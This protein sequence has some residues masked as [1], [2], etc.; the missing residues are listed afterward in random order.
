MQE[1]SS[2]LRPKEGRTLSA[3]VEDSSVG[4][5]GNDGVGDPSPEDD[6]LDNRGSLDLGF[7]VQVEDLQSLSGSSYVDRR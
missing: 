7:R 4:D 1:H 6:I 3:P 2:R 5:Q